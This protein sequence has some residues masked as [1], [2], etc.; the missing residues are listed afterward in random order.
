MK[1]LFSKNFTPIW[2]NY[3]F[4][5]ILSFTFIPEI[6]TFI[7]DTFWSS[8]L[9]FPKEAF[10]R[11]LKFMIATKLQHRTSRLVY[12]H[13]IELINAVGFPSQFQKIIDL[14]PNSTIRQLS[15]CFIEF[16]ISEEDSKQLS[17]YSN[18][19]LMLDLQAIATFRLNSGV[20]DTNISRSFGLTKPVS[21]IHYLRDSGSNEVFAN[22]RLF[23]F[24]VPSIFLLLLDTTSPEAR[25][26]SKF[27]N[28]KY[29]AVV[30][31][32]E[33]RTSISPALHILFSMD[34]TDSPRKENSAKKE[35]KTFNPPKGDKPGSAP[36][37][38]KTSTDKE[39]VVKEHSSSNVDIS[40]DELLK[41]V[42]LMVNSLNHISKSLLR[43][44]NSNAPSVRPDN[45][46]ILS[47]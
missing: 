28:L 19:M 8:R 36:K 7:K 5:I 25:D 22:T 10:E 30:T 35:V 21:P 39:S 3:R 42:V 43:Y 37:V 1:N 6:I 14:V 16:S 32:E 47:Y 23:S 45:E 9:P 33:Y 15:D 24:N 31:Q 41:S 12:E 27:A 2:K 29:K 44:I 11:L 46:L 18:E 40:K 4:Q 13:P 38:S 20:R 17:E 34:R 26:F